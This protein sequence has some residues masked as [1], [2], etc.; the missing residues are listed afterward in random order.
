[1]E[2][3][4]LMKDSNRLYYLMKIIRDGNDVYCIPPDLGMHFSLHASGESHFRKESTRRKPTRELPIALMMGEAGT[5]YARGII[6]DSI[7][8]LGRANGICTAIC[9]INSLDEDY[10]K[11]AGSIR[12]CF[13]I[14]RSLL[15]EHAECIELGIW[16]VPSRNI[17]SFEY[18]VPDIPDNLKYKI[19]GD[20]PQIWVYCRVS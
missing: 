5:P 4:I 9:T 15:P 3:R 20:E 18:N 8:N 17:A 19:T 11:Y 16:A 2:S 1:M 7:S 6:R 13:V 10:Q 14:D 12:E